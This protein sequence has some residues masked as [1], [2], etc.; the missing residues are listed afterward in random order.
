MKTFQDCCRAIIEQAES[1]PAPV[2]FAVGY[3]T[4]GQYMTRPDEIKVQ[5]IYILNNITHWRGDTARAVRQALKFYGGI[6]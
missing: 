1:N 5:S 3:A 2:N 6:K 4:A